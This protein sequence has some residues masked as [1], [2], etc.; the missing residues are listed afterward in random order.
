MT[1]RG[2]FLPLFCY[3]MRCKIL[4]P[5]RS[6]RAGLGLPTSNYGGAEPRGDMD[7]MLSMRAQGLISSR[8]RGMSL[9]SGPRSDANG[10]SNPNII[11]PSSP[12]PKAQSPSPTSPKLPMSTLKGLFAGPNRPRT[13]SLVG[14][15]GGAKSDEPSLLQSSLTS[16]SPPRHQNHHNHSHSPPITSAGTHILNRLRGNSD[17]RPLSPLGY[18]PSV[19]SISTTT[20]GNAGGNS[21][22]SVDSPFSSGELERKILLDQTDTTTSGASGSNWPVNQRK[23][24][25]IS[26]QLTGLDGLMNSVSAPLQP[27]PW[28]KH[29]IGPSSVVQSH[30]ENQVDLSEPDPITYQYLHTNMS[31]VE[32]FG[33][34]NTHPQ[35]RRSTNGARPSLDLSFGRDSQGSGSVNGSGTGG[36]GSVKGS[37]GVLSVGGKKPRPPSWT[38]TSSISESTSPGPKRWSRQG[39]LPKMLTPPSGA[40]P[41]IPVS[42]MEEEATTPRVSSPYPYSFDGDRSPSRSSSYSTQNSRVNSYS[43]SNTNSPQNGFSTT[44]FVKR[45]SGS[46]FQSATS[47]GNVSSQRTST[48]SGT[49]TSGVG[50][51]ISRSAL[52]IQNRLSLAPPQRPAPSTALPPTPTEQSPQTSSS[53]WSNPSPSP[54]PSSARSSFRESLTQRAVRLS[55]VGI[56]PKTPPTANLP[57]RPDD[58][59]FSPGHRRSNSGGSISVGGT[60]RPTTLYTIPGSPRETD[61]GVIPSVLTEKER[62]QNTPNLNL[63]QRLRMLSAP[64]STTAFNNS[65]PTTVSSNSSVSTQLLA[66]DQAILMPHTDGEDNYGSVHTRLLVGEPITTM[67]NDPSF[68]L[69]ATPVIPPPTPPPRLTNQSSPPPSSSFVPSN[70]SSP[71]PTQTKFPSSSTLPPPQYATYSQRS[72]TLAPLPVPPRSPFRQL[73]KPPSPAPSYTSRRSQPLP[74]PPPTQQFPPEI[75]SLSPPPWK[76]ARRSSVV[77]TIPP[78]EDSAGAGERDDRPPPA[79]MD[80]P[81][82]LAPPMTPPLPLTPRLPSADSITNLSI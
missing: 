41:S 33:V 61:P 80:S 57:L 52:S 67:Q 39:I 11:P 3:V 26:Q 50:S 44:L 14:L 70:P 2:F 43:N 82:L 1:C 75:T 15:N 16:I 18:T 20:N 47:T 65:P 17:A 46:S 5:H 60:S 69:M 21:V 35:S 66:A 27:P 71:L 68:L 55:L 40:L 59:S 9:N 49:G 62:Q 34:H 48:G 6:V 32:S 8:N 24:S 19:T 54:S 29:S 79:F 56:P 30:P 37:L 36:S 22:H 28:K 25:H 10:T 7:V 77:P 72:P 31:A 76:T 13:P 38:S 58:P 42:G 53:S 12:Q 51:Y 81:P 74:S 64:A 63:R 23:Q 78:K 4:I 73:P 45:Q